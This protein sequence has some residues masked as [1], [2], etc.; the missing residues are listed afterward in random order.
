MGQAQTIILAL[1][2]LRQEFPN[3]RPTLSIGL[4]HTQTYRFKKKTVKS[5][6]HTHTHTHTHLLTK[7]LF[8]CHLPKKA[9]PGHP[10]WNY[11]RSLT[12]TAF[13][14]SPPPLPGVY[15]WCHFLVHS[16]LSTA[17]CL[18]CQVR[19]YLCGSPD[20]CGSH[21][22]RYP[23]GTCGI[24]VVWKRPDKHTVSFGPELYTEQ[25]GNRS[26][27]TKGKSHPRVFKLFTANAVFYWF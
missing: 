19:D 2:R 23:A 14:M 8:I 3:W 11:V 15:F 4:T 5:H 6:T 24:S 26:C 12:T 20:T 1:K 22:S 17:C 18:C 10:C 9:H 21:R 13:L 7:S 16:L 27:H 25:R